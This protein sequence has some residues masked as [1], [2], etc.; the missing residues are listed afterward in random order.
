MKKVLATIFLG[1]FGWK[2]P[3]GKEAITRMKRSVMVAAPHTSNWDFPF[4]LAAFW[5]MG[6]NLKYFIKSEYTRGLFGWF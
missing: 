1:I 4:A 5:K 2:V 6:V 3:V